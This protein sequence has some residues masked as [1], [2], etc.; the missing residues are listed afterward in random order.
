MDTPAT[1]LK[2]RQ[3]LGFVERKLAPHAAVR[4]VVAIGSL[5]TGTSRP[6]SDIDAYVFLSPF[7]PYLVP[8][9][10][11]WRPRDDTFHTIFSDDPTLDEEGIQLDLHR[12]DFEEWSSPGFEWPEPSRAELA[13]GWLAYDRDG[14]VA[15]LIALRTAYPDDLRLRILDDAI[16]LISDHLVEDT[17]MRTWESLG[18]VVA[19]DRLQAVY[20]YVVK[21]L[22]AYNRRWRG[23]R[24]REMSAVLRLPWLPEGFEQ[25]ILG[26]AVAGGHD[27]A[28]YLERAGV[29]RELS[30]RLIGRLVDD[31]VYGSGEP[32][33]EAFIR[34]HDEPGRAWN[35]DDWNAEHARRG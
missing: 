19:G 11:V 7:D 14:E 34:I 35:M 13:G 2:R 5:A 8:A 32:V 22:F 21:A 15:R 27:L 6:G 25:R 33:D 28:A 17:L 18:P 24:N 20:E 4:G 23:W 29:L 16:P 9:E 10:S 30:E 3:L 12:V 1:E 26:A 31:G